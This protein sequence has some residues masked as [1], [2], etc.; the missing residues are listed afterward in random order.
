MAAGAALLGNFIEMEVVEIARLSKEDCLTPIFVCF[1][2]LP[3]GR[4]GIG[5]VSDIWGG[6]A[7]TIFFR[8]KGPERCLGS[9]GRAW[10]AGVRHGGSFP[11][12]KHTADKRLCFHRR[13]AG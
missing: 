8:N 3:G 9:R 12:I 10:K 7:L 4:G 1:L 13:A 5:F 6:G 11:L 2:Q